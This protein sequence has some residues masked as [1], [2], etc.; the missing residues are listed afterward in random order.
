MRHRNF[1]EGVDES[2]QNGESSKDMV[3][4]RNAELQ[5]VKQF[6]AANL[7]VRFKQLIITELEAPKVKGLVPKRI[8]TIGTV[9]LPVV[10]RQQVSSTTF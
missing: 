1:A 5:S 8:Q 7:I 4:A 2:G 10:V 6:Q 3:L 9:T